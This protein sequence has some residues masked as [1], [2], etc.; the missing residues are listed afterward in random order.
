[1]VL[2]E[3]RLEIAPEPQAPGHGKDRAQAGRF[4][5]RPVLSRRG[6]RQDEA[7]QPATRVPVPDE[8]SQEGGTAAP[9]VR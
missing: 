3:A 6:Q 8:G 4:L 9:A 7:A 2:D 5:C 1:V